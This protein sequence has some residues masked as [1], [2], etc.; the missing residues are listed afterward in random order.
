MELGQVVCDFHLWRLRL[1]IFPNSA[2]TIERFEQLITVK[3]DQ[4][5]RNNL[6]SFVPMDAGVYAA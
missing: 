6:T 4:E 5:L 2:P 1:E 3:I